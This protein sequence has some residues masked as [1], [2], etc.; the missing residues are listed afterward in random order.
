MEIKINININNDI[1][2][3]VKNVVEDDC[4]MPSSKRNIAILCVVIPFLLFLTGISSP[5]WTDNYILYV[6]CLLPFYTYMVI[7]KFL[8]NSEWQLDYV[9]EKKFY[10]AQSC[11]V[12]I[13]V[14]TVISILGGFFG[15]TDYDALYHGTCV[16]LAFNIPASFIVTFLIGY[17][18]S[19]LYELKKEQEWLFSICRFGCNKK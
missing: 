12:G 13:S 18:Y 1:E 4:K 8:V 7:I 19:C 14:P 6:F 5:F 3:N 11:F 17:E 15:F 16:I 2:C 10:A 9:S